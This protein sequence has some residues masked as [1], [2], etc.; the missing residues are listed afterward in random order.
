[1]NKG[2]LVAALEGRLG[3]KKAAAD[4]LDAV[5]DAIQRAVVNGEKVVITGFG[6]FE[7]TVRQARI[8]RNPQ[9]GA[10]VKIPEQAVPKFKAGA[11]FKGYVAEPKTLPKAK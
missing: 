9:T 4:A 11:A 5:V 10:E 8:G 1:M 7:R 6:T 2:E 3:S